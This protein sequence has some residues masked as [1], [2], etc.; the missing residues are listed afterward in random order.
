M[1]TPVFSIVR[2]TSSRVAEPS[3]IQ[4]HERTP[5]SHRGEAGQADQHVTIQALPDEVLLEIFTRDRGF[6]LERLSLGPWKWQ[7]LAHVCQRWRSLIFTSPCRLELR[8]YYTYRKPVT[9]D[10]SCWPPLPIAIFYPRF[11]P[12]GTADHKDEANVLAALKHRNRVCEINF[13]L[14]SPL[15]ERSALLM[16]EPFPALEQLRLRSRD[17]ATRPLTLPSAFLGGSAPRLRE[18]YLQSIAFP[19]LPQLLLSTPHLVSLQLDE[20]PRAETFS[21]EMLVNGLSAS[22][23]LQCLKLHFMFSVSHPGQSDARQLST[24]S[25]YIS[26]SSLTEFQFKGASEYLEDLVARVDAPSLQNLS[27]TFFD[28]PVFEIPQLSRFIGR[29]ER[30]TSP[31][32]ASI[33]FSVKDVAI[34]EQFQESPCPPEIRLQ[35]SCRDLGRRIASISHMC[36]QLSPLLLTVE[37]LDIKAFLLF[38]TRRQQDQIDPTHWLDLF[39]SFQGVKTLEVTDTLARNIALALEHATEGI[40]QDVFLALCDLRLNRSRESLSAS[41]VKFTAAR[42]LSGRP[43]SVHY[44]GESSP[45]YSGE[46]DQDIDSVQ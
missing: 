45:D 1:I 7:R 15:L 14:T 37:R 34:T 32:K 28:Q 5:A 12:S 20:I 30:L 19:T 42:Q 6:A 8:L 9:Q 44:R 24:S 25:S 46:G 18:I 31:R 13:A 23:Q 22:T 43:I 29:T 41:I 17:S 27:V 36:R 16:Q 11:P 21:P 26:L 4:Q 3:P 38:S 39:R 10:L 33:Q 35:L 40:T 2:R